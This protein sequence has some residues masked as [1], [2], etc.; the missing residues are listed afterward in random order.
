MYHSRCLNVGIMKFDVFDESITTME[1]LTR[2]LLRNVKL[3]L[4]S[5]Y[6]TFIPLVFRDGAY[7][8]KAAFHTIENISS[9]HIVQHKK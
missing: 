4:S 6:L 8:C 1:K 3:S 2:L 7:C 9:C 5:Y